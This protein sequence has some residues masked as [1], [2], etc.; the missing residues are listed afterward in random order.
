MTTD[1]FESH[2]STVLKVTK[3]IHKAFAERITSVLK[4]SLAMG[5]D[6]DKLNSEQ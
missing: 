3:N 1:K 4:S 2:L 6:F 5:D